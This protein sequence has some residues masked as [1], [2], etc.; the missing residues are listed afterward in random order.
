MKKVSCYLC[1][2]SQGDILFKQEGHDPYLAKVYKSA[3]DYDLN[4][5]IC[6]DCGFVLRF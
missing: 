5:M 2:S 1:V 3:P 6:N 4:W